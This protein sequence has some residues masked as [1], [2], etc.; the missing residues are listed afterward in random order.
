VSVG[1][2]SAAK[3]VVR[4]G[5]EIGLSTV[6]V[7]EGDFEVGARAVRVCAS[8]RLLLG[9]AKFYAC[10]CHCLTCG[11]AG[12]RWYVACSCM[13]FAEHNPVVESKRRLRSVEAA[14]STH[15]HAR[16]HG[17]INSEP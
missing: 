16:T 3:A 11:I 6:G 12:K 2:V 14:I 15:K 5:A 13:L 10:K 4:R 9:H 1:V 8:P 7:L 17:G